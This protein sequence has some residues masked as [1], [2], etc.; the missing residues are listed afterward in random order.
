MLQAGAPELCVPGRQDTALRELHGLLRQFVFLTR[1]LPL[2]WGHR[3]AHAH[4]GAPMA[5][6][7]EYGHQRARAVEFQVV[8]Q[9]FLREYGIL[10]RPDACAAAETMKKTS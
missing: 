3:D 4:D 6:C 10:V 2:M 9:L 1:P 5:M 8:H 7:S